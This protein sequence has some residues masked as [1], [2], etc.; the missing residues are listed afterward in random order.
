MN[1]TVV[2]WNQ[3][4]SPKVLHK[5]DFRSHQ[6]SIL[7][8]GRLNTR[9][10]FT[11]WNLLS[12]TVLAFLERLEQFHGPVAPA[13]G[14]VGGHSEMCPHRDISGV[15]TPQKNTFRSHWRCSFTQQRWSPGSPSPDH[16]RHFSL[17]LFFSFSYSGKCFD[18]Y[19]FCVFLPWISVLISC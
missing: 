5:P 3:R 18:H 10:T 13:A 12:F 14:S 19:L 2:N 15:R 16:K 11:N 9:K 1:Q 17:S 7:S 6:T 4:K 8:D